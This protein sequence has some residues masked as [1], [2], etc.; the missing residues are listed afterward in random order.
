MQVDSRHL[1]DHIESD[2]LSPLQPEE[3]AATLCADL[4]L[5]GEA[6]PLVAHAVHEE[7]LKHKKD[8]VEWGLLGPPD[9]DGAGAVGGV[10]RGRRGDA[11]RLFAFD[12]S[13][14]WRRSAVVRMALTWIQHSL[15]LGAT[16]FFP[17]L[18]PDVALAAG[19]GLS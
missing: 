6:V 10:D 18:G 7:L 1:V 8:A 4:G 5:G 11:G 2:L 17:S 19:R 9:D 12:P 14:Q 15:K 3:F 16:P 13:M